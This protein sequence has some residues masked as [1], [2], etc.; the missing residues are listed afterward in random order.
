V[1][2]RVHFGVDGMRAIHRHA[3][4]VLAGLGI[5]FSDAMFACGG[6]MLCAL[7]IDVNSQPTRGMDPVGMSNA[8]LYVDLVDLVQVAVDEN[9]GFSV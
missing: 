8:V 2:L 1:F 5:R 3:P 9:V 6:V 4:V 7:V